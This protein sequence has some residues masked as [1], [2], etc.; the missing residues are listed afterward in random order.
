MKKKVLIVDDNKIIREILTRFLNYWD[1]DSD[2]AGNGIEAMEMIKRK[3][4]DIVIT[5]NHMPEMSGVE[6]IRWIKTL[7]PSTCVIGITGYGSSEVLYKAGAEICFNKPF[8]LFEI[9]EEIQKLF[10]N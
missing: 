10:I 4:Y 7:Y 5:D 8:S 1:C 3:C 2:N 6:L 9:K